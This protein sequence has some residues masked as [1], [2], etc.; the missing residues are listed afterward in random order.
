M[1]A[2]IQLELAR[3]LGEKRKASAAGLSFFLDSAASKEFIQLTAN[4]Q[5]VDDN[6][7]LK[8]E[9]DWLK[10]DN[11]RLHSQHISTLQTEVELREQIQ[12][13][14]HH[15]TTT[16]IPAMRHYLEL[17]NHVRTVLPAIKNMFT[18]VGHI[19]LTLDG[20]ADRLQEDIKDNQNYIDEVMVN[21][22]GESESSELL[23]E[24]ESSEV[25]GERESSEVESSEEELED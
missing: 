24:P 1:A 7:A 19:D 2:V 9:N 11:D 25:L 6:K 12:V 4:A 5:L 13:M 14:N 10:L 23:G 22:L 8:L 17:K 21:M 3:S 18:V 15:V 16:V 20:A